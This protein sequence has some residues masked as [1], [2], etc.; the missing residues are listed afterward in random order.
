MAPQFR[1]T[2]AM[3]IETSASGIG[4]MLVSLIGYFTK[5]WISFLYGN[6]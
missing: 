4:I 1:A 2:A 3:I 6:G 5:S